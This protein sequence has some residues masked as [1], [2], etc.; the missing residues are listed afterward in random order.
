MSDERGNVRRARP[1][2]ESD[3]ALGPESAPATLI[4]YGDYECPH[5]RRLHPIIRELMRRTEGLRCVFRHFPLSQVHPHAVRAAEAAEA[6]AAQGRF[7]QMHDA[8]FDNDQ[9]LDDER[10]TRSAK[11]AGLDMERYAREMAEGV[12]AA[13]VEEDFKSALYND[14]VTGTPTIYLN[15]S[16][17]S[18]N[19]SLEVLLEAV[20]GAGANLSDDGGAE[21]VGLLARLRKLRIGKSRLHL[22]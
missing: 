13:R 3:H 20:R 6:A 19:K 22:R 12:Y 16:L 21:R 10:L 8:L 15:G 2:G 11:R 7:W 17:L 5:C 1:V 18:D 4:E 9:P 14:G